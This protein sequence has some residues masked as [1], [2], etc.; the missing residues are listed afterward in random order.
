KDPGN[1]RLARGPSVRLSAEMI[2]DQAL[3][4]A[5]LLVERV[6]GP[7]VKPYQP[8]WLWSEIGNGTNAYVQDHG[9]DLYRRSLYTFWK[10]TIPPPSL[11][12]FDASAREAHVV[13]VNATDTPLQ[14]LDLMNDVTYLEAARAFAQRVMREGGPSPQA[15]IA[16]ALYLATAHRPTTAE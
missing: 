14:A 9:E 5:G 16:Y 7:S 1:R 10:R 13:R 4:I 3:S 6:G 12:N 15:R 2:R 11:S 8:E